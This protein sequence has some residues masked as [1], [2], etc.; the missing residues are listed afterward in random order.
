M[1]V[2]VTTGALGLAGMY[3]GPSLL[4]SC[5]HGFTDSSSQ[6]RQNSTSVGKWREATH[7]WCNKVV[8]SSSGCDWWH[9]YFSG[10]PASGDGATVS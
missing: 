1:T 10:R 4:P 7:G 8:P 5:R 6:K 9:V 2:N 3:V